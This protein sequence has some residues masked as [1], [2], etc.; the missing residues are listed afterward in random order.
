MAVLE[1]RATESLPLGGRYAAIV[2]DRGQ[3]AVTLQ[4]DRFGVWPLCWSRSG[5][6]LYFADRADAVA[7]MTSA[8]IDPQALYD[9]LYFHM[10]PAPRTVF[11]G[12]ARIEPATAV[13]FTSNRT[14]AAT[15]WAP[16]FS[17]APP[18]RSR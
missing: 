18:R 2:I 3:H 9:Y 10:I 7:E 1:R 14:T 16:D 17:R 8:G 6:R 5:N 4:T 12:V 13:Q 15:A 11:L